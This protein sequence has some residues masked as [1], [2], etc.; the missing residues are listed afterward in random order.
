MKALLS[1]TLVLL[2]YLLS[3]SYLIHAL[4]SLPTYL[5]V[6]ISLALIAPLG[7]LMGMPFPLGIKLT[8]ENA[9]FLVPWCWSINGAFSV[10]AS[11]VSVVIAITFGFSAAMALGGTAYL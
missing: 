7:W 3:L 4:I 8:S 2:V 10:L 1:L 9:Q 5:K 6:F 11:V